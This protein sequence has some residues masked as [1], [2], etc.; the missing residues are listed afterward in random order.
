MFQIKICGVC[1]TED[2]T[3]IAH[4]GADAIGLNFYRPSPRSVSLNRAE[5]TA[6]A[7]R[8]IASPE[9]LAIVG[10]FVNAPL[11]QIEQTIA[12]V[13]LDWVQ[14]HGDETVDSYPEI[15]VPVIRAIRFL[16]V[17]TTNQQ[18]AQWQE[19]GAQAILLD[20]NTTTGYGGTGE[21]VDWGDAKPVV[22]TLPI[23]LAGGLTPDN[24]AQA[25]RTFRPAAID[26]ASGVESSP[27]IKDLSLVNALVRESQPALKEFD[28]STDA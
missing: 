6:Q 19:W 22:R 20:A 18:I 24:V 1:R 10:V 21:K 5:E 2:A 7:I 23:V 28:S 16:D 26:A 11:D 13:G 8:L 17:V 4:S 15:S 25:I 27:G 14:L 9:S 12:Q 3:A